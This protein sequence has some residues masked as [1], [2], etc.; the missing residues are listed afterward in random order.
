MRKEIVLDYR[1]KK[2]DFT[3][4]ESSKALDKAVDLLLLHCGRYYVTVQ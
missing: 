4:G 3:V 1:L 2:Q